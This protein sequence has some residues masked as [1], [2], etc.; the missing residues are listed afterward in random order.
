MSD[1]VISQM[2]E[3]GTALVPTMINLDRFPIYAAPA[4]ERFPDYFTHMH[5]LYDRRHETIGRAIEAG[6]TVYSGTDAGT[7]VRH[8]RVRDEI[9]ELAKLAGNEYAL[10]ASSWHARTWLGGTN[11]TDGASADLIVLDADPRL[12]LTTL[13]RPLALVLRGRRIA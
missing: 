6:I 12:D 8:G 2:V 11:I 4:E 3:R 5:H 7:V 1:E 10:G 9:D 13:R